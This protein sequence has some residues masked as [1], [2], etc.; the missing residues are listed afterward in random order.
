M[1]KK[2]AVAWVILFIAW[3]AGSFV[4]HGALLGGAYAELPNLFRTETETQSYMPF[5]LI[6]HVIMAGAFVWIYR[7]GAEAKP[8]LM[9]GVRF[10][11]AVALL[12]PVP[13]YM[14]YYVVQPLPVQLVIGQIAGDS[15]LVVLLGM[16]VAFLYKDASA[17]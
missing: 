1:D 3:M 11:I 2:F 16:I 5:M 17:T 13:M 9:Q 10:G 8:W 6:A 14:I 15:L 7:R 4:V 12:A